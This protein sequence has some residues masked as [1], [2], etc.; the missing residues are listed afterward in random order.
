[1]IG[2]VKV[3]EF[4]VVVVEVVGFVEWGWICW[5]AWYYGELLLGWRDI[6]RRS[7]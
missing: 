1:M 7:S 6:R 3:Q 5:T 4:G 2:V